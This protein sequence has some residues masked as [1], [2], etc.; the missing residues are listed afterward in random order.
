MAG[1][2]FKKRWQSFFTS[3]YRFRQQGFEQYNTL[4]TLKFLNSVLILGAVLCLAVLLIQVFTGISHMLPLYPLLLASFLSLLLLLRKKCSITMVSHA[5]LGLFIIAMYFSFTGGSSSAFV[6]IFF[7][8]PFPVGA[9]YLLGK[10]E[11]GFWVAGYAAVYAILTL[12]HYFNVVQNPHSFRYILLGFINLAV[13]SFFVYLIA[14]RHHRIVGFMEEQIYLDPLTS[15]KNRKKLLIDIGDTEAPTLFLINVDDFKEINAIFGYRIGDS[16]LVFLARIFSNIL[17]DF[18]Q[19]VYKLAGDEFAVLVDMHSKSVTQEMIEQTARDITKYVQKERYGYAKYEIML[20]VSV[21]IA[22]AHRVGVRSLFS[23]ADIALRTAKQLRKPFMFYKDAQTTRSKFE[24]NLKWLKILAD[25]IEYDRIVPYYQPIV[26]NTTGEIVKYE[27]LARI[28]DRGGRIYTPEFFMSIAKKSR[29]YDK[30]TRAIIRK[31]FEAFKENKTEF[32]INM[33]VEDFLDPYTLQYIKFALSEFPTLRNRVSF[34]ILETE[35]VTDFD[36]FA[37]YIADMKSVGCKIAIDDFGAGY[38]NFDVLLKLQ[39]DY[40]KIDGVL[41]EKMDT[42]TNSRI[43][44]ENIV[45]FSRKMGI[46]TIAE[47][48][49]SRKIYDIVRSLGIDYSQGFFLGEPKPAVL[50]TMKNAR[51][52]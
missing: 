3:G 30:I 36:M 22:Q 45:N 46:E 39:L 9:F 38:S 16:V 41:I 27:C 25:A 33:S 37:E 20:R 24:E 19:G 35:S 40:L 1:K 29:L 10:R 4:T 43:I 7:I 6:S 11:G 21:G 32:S 13:A 34:E 52:M 17:P 23:C 12:L 14:D 48:V 44:V 28:A 18:V 8:I 26:I 50:D 15:L 31:T 5:V 51:F 2:G 47:Y 42:D 49:H